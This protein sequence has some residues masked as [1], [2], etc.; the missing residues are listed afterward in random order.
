MKSMWSA[1]A[2]ELPSMTLTMIQAIQTF[3]Q[4][5]SLAPIRRRLVNNRKYQNGHTIFWTHF[6]FHLVE[7][8]NWNWRL[9]LIFL[10]GSVHW[11]SRDPLLPSYWQSRCSSRAQSFRFVFLVN[12]SHCD[13]Q[14][15]KIRYKLNSVNR[16]RMRA[17]FTRRVVNS[18][19]LKS[20][21]NRSC[22]F[23]LSS[24]VK[25]VA[26]YVR[27]SR[28]LHRKTDAWRGYLTVRLPAG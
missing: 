1:L 28:T 12:F 16:T 11:E 14:T 19:L 8:P 3:G 6:R 26:V 10:N 18:R 22:L 17:S 7:N 9:P 25:R 2:L 27:A 5:N 24:P 15:K 23:C 13:S 20:G 4:L 21:S